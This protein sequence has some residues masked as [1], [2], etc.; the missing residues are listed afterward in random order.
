M[1][2]SILFPRVF[3]MKA[4]KTLRA[5][6]NISAC[7]ETHVFNFLCMAM[8]RNKGKL[9]IFYCKQLCSK[10]KKPL[11]F[12]TFYDSLCFRLFSLMLCLIPGQNVPT[13]AWYEIR[14]WIITKPHVQHMQLLTTG[15]V[16]RTQ[17]CQ[18]ELV[19]LPAGTV[20]SHYSTAK[21]LSK[22]L[23]TQPLGLAGCPQK[24]AQHQVIW[25]IQA[26]TVYSAFYITYLPM[27]QFPIQ[28]KL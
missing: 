1:K 22:F 15:C 24:R 27:W 10:T 14:A 12:L 3:N 20:K 13:L 16:K 18:A 6:Q 23:P 11:Y 17:L 25:R 19:M 8:I 5:M 4:E 26:P 2:L 21:E 28:T 9:Y 7:L